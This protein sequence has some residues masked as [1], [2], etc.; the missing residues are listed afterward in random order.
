MSNTTHD[1]A[2]GKPSFG[3]WLKHELRHGL[4]LFLYLWALL[5]LF[6]LNEDLVHR[7]AGK[8]GRSPRDQPHG[9]KDP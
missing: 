3:T 7:A 5:G 8:R 1:K 4:I 2:G 6:V 9:G